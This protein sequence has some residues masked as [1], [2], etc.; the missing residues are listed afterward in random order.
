MPS[1]SVGIHPGFGI[2]PRVGTEPRIKPMCRTPWLSVGWL[3]SFA[4]KM[5]IN[6]YNSTRSLSC[7]YGWSLHPFAPLNDW[8]LDYAT[9]ATVVTLQSLGTPLISTHLEEADPGATSFIRG[10]GHIELQWTQQVVRAGLAQ[11]V[12]DLADPNDPNNHN[13][14]HLNNADVVI[15]AERIDLR[16]YE[17]AQVSLDLRTWDLTTGFE[18]VDGVDAYALL[19]YDGTN[20]NDRVPLANLFL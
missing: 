5:S 17:G 9:D 1:R 15:A 10:P 8:I 18:G 11:V 3:S 12:N 6:N 4:V 14:Y 19:S 16:G 7:I 20:F 13:Q 2:G